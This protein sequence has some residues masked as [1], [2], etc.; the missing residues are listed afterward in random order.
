[1]NELDFPASSFDLIWSEGA[2]YIMGFANGLHKCRPMLKPGGYLMFSEIVYFKED[3]PDDLISFWKQ[4]CP[5]MT[6][7]KENLKLIEGAGYRVIDHF[8]LPEQAWW[9]S[10]YTHLEKRVIDFANR[11]LSD[12]ERDFL[13]ETRFEIE[14][15][16]KYGN[17][18][19]YEYFVMK[20]ED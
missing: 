18:Y 9:D 13:Q 16:R 2:I 4:E 6:T 5:E 17:L 3:C 8:P 1:M 19:G 15:F 20:K 11:P 12:E 14:L 10:Y 7:V